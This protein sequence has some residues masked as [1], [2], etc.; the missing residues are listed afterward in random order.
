MSTTRGRFSATKVPSRLWPWVFQKVRVYEETTSLQKEGQR[1]LLVK[2]PLITLSLLWNGRLHNPPPYPRPDQRIWDTTDITGS[3]RI[4]SPGNC[5]YDR[6][7]TEYQVPSRAETTQ[8]KV[9]N[10]Q[11]V[12]GSEPRFWSSQI[13]FGPDNQ[14]DVPLLFLVLLSYYFQNYRNDVCRYRVY[15]YCERY[16]VRTRFANVCDGEVGIPVRHP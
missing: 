4:L 1:I 15:T 7:T 2:G 6:L 16:P 9:L 14:W 3:D 10:P 11:R 5:G 8:K 12:L 13:S